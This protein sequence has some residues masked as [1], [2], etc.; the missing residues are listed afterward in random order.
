[1]WATWPALTKCPSSCAAPSPTGVLLVPA[2]RR[3]C[4][5]ALLSGHQQVI[6]AVQG[7]LVQDCCACLTCSTPISA[8]VPPA[9]TSIPSLPL[10][11]ESTVPAAAPTIWRWPRLERRLNCYSQDRLLASAAHDRV[12]VSVLCRE[13]LAALLG[14][15]ESF[16]QR[17]QPLTSLDKVGLSDATESAVQLRLVLAPQ[18]LGVCVAPP[19]APAAAARPQCNRNNSS[20]GEHDTWAAMCRSGMLR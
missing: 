8:P 4:Q 3:R 11:F 12:K 19:E 6:W 5:V 16:H 20:V 2:C 18:V 10:Y 7:R 17:T 14:Y 13:Y 9:N 15:L 1:M